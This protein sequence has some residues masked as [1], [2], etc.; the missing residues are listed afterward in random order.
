[1]QATRLFAALLLTCAGQAFAATAPAYLV[2]DHSTEILM[3]QAKAQALWEAELPAKLAKIY[4]V[5]K[6]GFVTEVEG[7]FDND[8]NCVIT[9]RTMMMPR[10]GK[11]LTF[12]PAK[13]ATT[14]GVQNASSLEQCQTLA[15]TKLNE[16]ISAVRSALLKD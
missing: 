15:K 8:K 12:K 16:S 2:V 10:N 3:N 7:G 5:K 4:P 11:A 6:W 1:M 13:T 14:Y 9:A